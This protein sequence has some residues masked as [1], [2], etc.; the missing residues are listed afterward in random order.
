VRVPLDYYRILCLPP[1]ASLDQ[2]AQAYQDR[3]ALLQPSDFSEVALKGRQALLKQAHDYLHHPDQRALYDQQFL[4]RA[5]DLS[6]NTLI[7]DSLGL[8]GRP[9]LDVDLEHLPG[10]LLILLE[11]GEYESVLALGKT[12]PQASASE[13]TPR[14]DL[15]HSDLLLSRALAY[16][17][18]GKEFLQRQH[19]DQA[20][21]YLQEGLLLLQSSGRFPQYIA[22]IRRQLDCLRPF[23]ILELVA[24][25][26][27]QEGDRQEGLQLLQTMLDTRGGIEGV[28]NDRSGMDVDGFLNFVQQIRT[29]LTSAEQQQLFEREAKRPSFSGQY[30]LAYTLLG[31]GFAERQ[32]AWVHQALSLMDRMGSQKD[33]SLERSMANLL[34]GRADTALEEIAQSPERSVLN[35]IDRL[36]SHSPD[37]LSGLCSY[38]KRWLKEGVMPHFRDLAHSEP[39]L[40]AYF[41]DPAVQAYLEALPITPVTPPLQPDSPLSSLPPPARI[42]EE[43]SPHTALPQT[44]LALENPSLT[45]PRRAGRPRASGRSRPTRSKLPWAIAGVVGLLALASFGILRS[46]KSSSPRQPTA[47]APQIELV[48]APVSPPSGTVPP[49]ANPTPRPG[50]D[51]LTSA[52]AQQLLEQWF[53]AKASALGEQHDTAPLESI[54]ANPMLTRWQQRAELARANGEAYTYSHQVRVESLEPNPTSPLELTVRARVDESQEV[55][56]DGTPQP[57]MAV[58]DQGLQVTYR[59]IRQNGQWRIA[60]SQVQ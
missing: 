10:A 36:S 57:G 51:P 4:D 60:D 42:Q 1:Q 35:Q 27:D 52:Q 30:L 38:C 8:T 14:D 11:L 45:R 33:M 2:I 44:P 58:K 37:R 26:L 28:Q 49:P 16:R 40:E 6:L 20:A 39:D 5:K 13:P 21:Q 56:I 3:L 15:I 43:R 23:R 31:R 24:L 18:L 53:K 29:Y 34:L 17:H 32:A 54:L 48:P 50:S 55:V 46:C 12:V 22:D 9:S 19:F 47:T 41:A 59:L 25:P 7:S